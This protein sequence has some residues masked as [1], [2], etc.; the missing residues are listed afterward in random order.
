MM[1]LT[2]YKN[3]R[4]FDKTPEPTGGK[5]VG[6]TLQFVV[7]KHHAS[8]LH[9]DFRLEMEGVLKSWAVPKGP[10]MN[11]EDKRLAMMVEDHPWDYKDFE[12]IIPEGY[13]KGTVIV[14]DRGTY[15][16]IK[17]KKTKKEN[18]KSLLHHLY[19]GSVTFVLH[20]KKLK[21]E[22]ALIK[23][24]DRG[25][26]AWL[27]IKKKDKLSS[28]IDVTKKDKSV[29]SNKTL[30]QVK[31]TSDKIWKSHRPQ[32][33][34][35]KKQGAQ[36]TNEAS[37]EIN[38]L[39]KKGRKS[40]FPK[41]IKPMLCTLVKEPFN[42]E[43]FLYEAKLDGYRVIAFVKEHKATLISRSGLNYSKYYTPVV[44]ELASFDFDMV[45]DGEV[46]VLNEEGEP[47]FDALQK[48]K[49]DAPLIFY[50][51]DLLWVKGYDI[52]DL[53]LE[54]RKEILLKILPESDVVKYSIHFD[55][56]L[57][58]FDVVK[59]KG[60]E[61]IVA[62]RRGSKYLPG[63]RGK[64]W[65]KIP[66]EKRQE[67]IIGGWTESESGSA[68]RT[69]L[70]GAYEKEKLKFIG[71]AGG[72]FKEKEKP[73]IKKRLKKLEI[74]K[75][76]FDNEVDADT[77]VHYVKPKLVAN[78]KFAT[79]TQSGRIRKPAIFLGFRDDKEPKE[80]IEE[81]PIEKE[82]I[83][84][85]VRDKPDEKERIKTSTD[86]NWKKIENE[87][88]TSEETF[89]IEA[90]D[91]RITNVEKEIWKDITKA[92]LITYYNN[93]ADYIL[94]H[95]KDRPL[96][97]NI[98]E[99]GISKPDLYIKDMEGRQPD[100]AEVF[101]TKRKH[102]KHGK[103]EEIDYLVCQNR[104]TLLYI[105]NLGCRDVNPWTARTKD[106][107]H[108]DYIVI[109]LDPSD[110]D[111]KK[112]IKAAQTAKKIFDKH[113]LTAFIKTSGKTGLH[114]YVPCK[115][116]TF[117]EARDIAEIICEEIKKSLPDITT[118]E[119]TIAHRGSKLYLDP[120]QND[121]ADTVAAPYSVRPY[122]IPTVSTPL[123]WKEITSKLNASDFTINTI[124]ER[125]SKKK[126]LFKGVLDKKIAER[127]SRI[128]KGFS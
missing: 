2:A 99:G 13:G 110:N 12:G 15:E 100:Y 116:F 80:V 20:G 124:I 35:A 87:K 106:P 123:E 23:T 79:W 114:I 103:R 6:D 17:K 43:D 63:K 28:N 52:I 19:Q 8:H 4:S 125:L 5:P 36:Q 53:P 95:L 126:D 101:T 104:A 32:K 65:L 42:D 47:D 54:Q 112:A 61:G 44:D 11:P 27:L 119:V 72:G 82:I 60:M 127:N 122:H 108:P 25:D 92:D 74:K 115:G 71:H 88:V 29:L 64:D 75:N 7:Q 57:E 22:F 107:L 84:N 78:I 10:S 41:S 93:V 30:E 85:E 56:G 38:D 31:A 121:E 105:I 69:L 70:F 55:N 118:T 46:V 94:P 48:Y 16:P 58:L 62:K 102:K 37:P 109:D 24:K 14:W 68:F 91:V 77:E 97:L 9:Y 98:K 83:Q 96:S 49:G 26:N 33:D 50:A 1:G 34:A 89:K 21:G 18:E 86:S 3:K 113:K 51:F 111:F 45:V 39:I 117:P 128:L 40:A 76:P 73:L 59:Q 67:F 120:N 90:H 81:I 66:T